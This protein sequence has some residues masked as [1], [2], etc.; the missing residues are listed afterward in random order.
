MDKRRTRSRNMRKKKEKKFNWNIIIKI[1]AVLGFIFIA[2]FFSLLN[3]GSKNIINNVYI[4]GI[5]VSSLSSES[6]R[7]KLEPILEEKLSKEIAVKYGEY[8]T[9]ILPAEI[10]FSYD[11]SSS[12]EKAYAVGRTGNIITNNL[13]ILSSLFMKTNIDLP[14]SYNTDQLNKIIEN[15]SVEIPD[16]VVEPSYYIS[17]D[18]LILTKGSE[19]NQLNKEKTKEFIIS[20]IENSSSEISLPVS[21]VQPEAID[22][23]KIHE[24]IYCEPQ[25]ASVSK[26]PDTIS[27]EKKGVDFA[28]SVEEAQNILNS[29]ESNEITIPLVYKNAEITVADLGEDIF[30]NRI[31]YSTTKYD[32]TNVNRA[33]NLEIAASKIDGIVLEPGEIFSFNKVVGER[34]AKNGF[35]EAIIYS[36]GE[37]DYG[38]GG[39]ICQIS[40]NLY[41]TAL[42]A[43]LN[44][45]ERKNHSMTVNYLPIGCDAT[46]SYGSVDFKFQ[47]SRSYPIKISAT[48]V[49]GVITVSIYGVSEE[50]EYKVD[51]VVET[52]QKDDYETVYEYSSSV[53]EG[54]EQIKQTGKYG[55]KC[56]TYRVLYQ[57]GKMVSKDLLSTDTYKTQKQ[58][59]IKHK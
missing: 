21:K 57:N 22:M 19:G 54:T 40:S 55:Y 49:S 2:T 47:N 31:A 23:N 45:I 58:I 3:M 44:I 30:K 10:N 53:P 43:N 25:N 36:D 46:V 51:I 4:D 6:A 50:N 48:V 20:A 12:L 29:S 1:S 17:N 15:M 37:L 13:K 9:T 7:N 56:S 33:T 52:T 32:S 11:L 18:E 24:D 16:L 59:V 27:V 42:K 38:I 8:E 14:I 35:K 28:I 34:T 39:G 41:Y 26:N 5:S